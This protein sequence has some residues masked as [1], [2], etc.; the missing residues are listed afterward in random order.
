VSQCR[1]STSVYWADTSATISS[2]SRFPIN[3]D[4]NIFISTS[5]VTNFTPTV[6]ASTDSPFAR[7][8]TR[9]YYSAFSLFET[10]TFL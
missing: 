7:L 3:R 2:K 10:H 8:L 4:G 6:F 9:Q 1:N 5:I